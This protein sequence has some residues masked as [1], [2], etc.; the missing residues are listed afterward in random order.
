MKGQF[1]IISTV[2]MISVMILITQY[3]YDYG[4][5]NLTKIEE[6]QELSYIKDI[7]DSLTRTVKV[8]CETG[9]IVI[10]QNNL[11][12]TEQFLK[13]QMLGKGIILEIS[14]TGNCATMDFDYIIDS[15]EFHIE[16]SFSV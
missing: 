10:L 11:E 7:E 9:D 5:I 14:H 13:D 4:K 8:A 16:N 6:M 1:F 15:N 12:M 3:L 2:I